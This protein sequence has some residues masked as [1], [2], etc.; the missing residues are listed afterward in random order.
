MRRYYQLNKQKRTGIRKSDK[1]NYT[2]FSI[3]KFALNETHKSQPGKYFPVLEVCWLIIITIHCKY[4][5]GYWR[6]VCVCHVNS[7]KTLCGELNL[8]L[9]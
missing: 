8:K 9:T 3:V 6:K 4:L 2:H 1:V 7:F 5:A